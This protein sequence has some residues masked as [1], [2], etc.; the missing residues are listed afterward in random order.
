[1]PNLIQNHKSYLE[2]YYYPHSAGAVTEAQ[3][4]QLTCKHS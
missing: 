1:M 4:E 2:E 3:S